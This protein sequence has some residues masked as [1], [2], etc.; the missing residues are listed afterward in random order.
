MKLQLRKK[1]GFTKEVRDISTN[2]ICTELIRIMKFHIGSQNAIEKEML[3]LKIFHKPFEEDSAADYLRWH[4]VKKAMHKLRVFSNCFI[5]YTRSYDKK[6]L[7]FFVIET[8]KDANFYVNILE[9]NKRRMEIMQRKAIRSVNEKWAKQN[10]VI[11]D[12]SR[13][14][15]GLFPFKS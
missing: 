11:M 14:R 2:K 8:M 12:T 13:K 6:H 3:F 4:F 10:W 5:T 7:M 15:I 9:N 1:H